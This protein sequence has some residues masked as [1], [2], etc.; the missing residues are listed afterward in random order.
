MRLYDAL[1]LEPK[2]KLDPKDLQERFYR[3]SRQWH[4]DRFSRAGADEQQQAQ[5]GAGKVIQQDIHCG[6]P[7]SGPLCLE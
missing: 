2:L 1:E 3:L 7:I 5:T 4:P 6:L